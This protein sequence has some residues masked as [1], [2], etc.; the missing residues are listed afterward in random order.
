MA[1]SERSRCGTARHEPSGPNRV[2][3][4][5]GKWNGACGARRPV[6]SVLVL[7]LFAACT[8]EVEPSRASLGLGP[9][10]GLRAMTARQFQASVRAVVGEDAPV[11]PVG[12]W[13]SS[14]A[15]ARGG[16]AGHTML[17][18]E[19]EA[20]RVGR[21][22]FEDAG[23]R[24]ALAGCTPAAS[25]VD[26]CLRA[27]IARLGRR[28]FH[29]TLSAEEL[30]RYADLAAE[31]GASD[32][33]HGLAMAVTGLLQ[34]P[35]FLYRVELA[36]ERDP[37]APS[38]RRY[39]ATEI[40]TRL[41][42]FLWNAP[43]DDSLLDLAERGELDDAEGV[44]S[45]ARAMLID[46][47]SRAGRENLFDELFQG[48]SVE[49]ISKDADL[50]PEFDAGLA[51]AMRAQLARAAA[52]ASARGDVRSIFT[53]RTTFLND[54]LA[55]IYGM[56]PTF[57]SDLVEVALPESDGHAGLLTTPAFLAIAAHPGKTSPALRG[58]FVRK[59]LLCQE[60]PPPPPGVVTTLRMRMEG[61]LVTTR[62]LVAEH[63]RDRSCAACHSRMD[64]IGLGLEQFDAIGRF[65]STENELAI[66]PSGDLDGVAFANAEELGR[67]IA[68]HPELP[69]CLSRTF[70]AQAA[71]R[72]IGARQE[73]YAS[74]IEAAF[75]AD[76]YSLNA[77]LLAI[78]TSDPFLHAEQP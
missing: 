14:L 62:E 7:V 2:L 42:Y 54:R 35:Y 11:E 40:A 6:G 23:R 67:S 57:G 68:A 18:Y 24:E 16:I 63:E 51:A 78:V 1:V 70:F 43:P 36:E 66:D 3:G 72:T 48:A 25:A 5:V 77:A 13:T 32:P 69:G 37:D 39:S 74:E 38:L 76:G 41:S 20:Q 65:R 30:D 26:P 19:T 55:P 29:R 12:P 73:V 60:I 21:W 8:G 4:R 56:E 64:P 61:E 53:T 52:H 31:L 27:V 50:F 44:R 59:V 34:S 58:L 45:A 28:A 10:A 46:P 47:R 22:A 9:P 71:G 15:A 75:A 33:W 17:A 49:A